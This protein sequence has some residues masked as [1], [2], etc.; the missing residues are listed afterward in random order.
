MILMWFLTLESNLSWLCNLWLLPCSS[1]CIANLPHH[2]GPY[3]KENTVSGLFPSAKLSAAPCFPLKLCIRPEW[4]Q[5]WDQSPKGPILERQH[6]ATQALQL[7]PPL[8]EG[9]HEP[10]IAHRRPGWGTSAGMFS[11]LI[12]YP[13]LKLFMVH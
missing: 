10:L 9:L 1:Q 3:A 12:T 13:C 7:F 4:G 5:G 11:N 8:R 6:R 2:L